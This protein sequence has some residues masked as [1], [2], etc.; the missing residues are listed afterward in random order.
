MKNILGIIVDSGRLLTLNK[1]G[2]LVLPHLAISSEKSAKNNGPN[3]PPQLLYRLDLP[4]PEIIF[5]RQD[6]KYYGS[7]ID[8]LNIDANS[9]KTLPSGFNVYCINEA[10]GLN[11]Y[12]DEIIWVRNP[13]DPNLSLGTRNIAQNLAKEGLITL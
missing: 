5:T 13:L 7:M 2:Q 9:K 8:N 11:R 12:Q 10:Q 1:N 6:L 3:K 4:L